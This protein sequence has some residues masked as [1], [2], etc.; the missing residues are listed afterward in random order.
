VFVSVL[1]GMW[2]SNEQVMIGFTGYTKRF[3]VKVASWVPLFED[4]ESTC[5]L[6][7]ASLNL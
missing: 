7:N 3:M 1:I 2:Y 4:Y 6:V 5:K